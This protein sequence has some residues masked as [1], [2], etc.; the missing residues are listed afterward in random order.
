MNKRNR[1]G[2]TLNYLAIQYAK[3]RK[4]TYR[5]LYD[6][7]MNEKLSVRTA[8]AKAKKATKLLL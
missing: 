8:V 6:R 2:F 3:T 7:L 1:T 4:R 5:D